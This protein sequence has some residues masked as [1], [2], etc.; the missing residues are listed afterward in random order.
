MTFGARGRSPPGRRG[1]AGSELGSSVSDRICWHEQWLGRPASDFVY[2]VTWCHRRLYSSSTLLRR[3]QAEDPDPEAVPL[4]FSD[5]REEWQGGE[6]VG[7][8]RDE[9]TDRPC[10]CGMNEQLGKFIRPAQEW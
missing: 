3:V 5:P 9:R 4:G 8:V 7:S 10:R 6:A 2:P 1:T